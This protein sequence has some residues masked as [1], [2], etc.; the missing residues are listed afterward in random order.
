LLGHVS[1]GY[2]TFTN[3][4]ILMILLQVYL[5]YNS[6]NTNKFE[7]THQLSKITSSLLYLYGVISVISSITLFTILNKF[8]ADG[9]HLLK[10]VE[11][12]L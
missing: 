6:I 5:V 3:I 4:T 12:K 8:S 9:F 2:S 11:P 7:S 10:K 1:S